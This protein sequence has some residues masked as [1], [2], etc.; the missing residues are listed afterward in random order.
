MSQPNVRFA[1]W[2]YHTSEEPPL[3]RAARAEVAAGD[4]PQCRHISRLFSRMLPP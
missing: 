2:I 3:S 1:L 4:H